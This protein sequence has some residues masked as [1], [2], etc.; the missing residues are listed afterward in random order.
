MTTNSM[1]EPKPEPIPPR[2]VKTDGPP[3]DSVTL[4]KQREEIVIQHGGDLYRLRRTRNG[5]LILTK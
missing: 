1:R 4:F 3:L 2:P 5:K